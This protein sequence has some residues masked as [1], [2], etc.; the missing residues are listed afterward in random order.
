MEDKEVLHP[1][2]VF[3]SMKI[4]IIV[5]V[6]SSIASLL[7]GVA[8]LYIALRK[9]PT[10]VKKTDAEVKKTDAETDNLHAQVADRWAEHVIELQ[11]QVRDLDLDVAQ[12]RRENE[13]YRVKL[14]E[15]D[16]IIAER[17]QAISDLKD[18]AER[19]MRQLREHAPNVQ[20]ES[21]ISHATKYKHDPTIS[22][23]G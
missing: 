2:L 18:W 1:L 17:D 21:F 9:T 23:A 15:R 20:P 19:L 5:A 8:A 16:Q 10:E 11:T 7:A 14:A 6:V 13:L 3:I 12:V 4:E 22:G